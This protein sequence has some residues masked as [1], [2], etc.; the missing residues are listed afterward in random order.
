MD[1]PLATTAVEEWARILDRM[2][3]DTKWV[4]DH[5]AIDDKRLGVRAQ[6]NDL[7]QGFIGGAVDVET[8]R[9]TLDVKTRSEW[10]LFGIKG[11]SG[12]MFLNMLVKYVTDTEGLTEQLRSALACPANGDEGRSKMSTFLSYLDSL[13]ST[14]TPTK[15]QIQPARAPFLLSVCWH[16]QDVEAWPVF[17][18]SGRK[19]LAKEGLYKPTFN[20]VEDY[21]QFRNVFEKLRAVLGLGP[22]EMEHLL[23]WTVQGAAV[24]VPGP[25]VDE[26]PWTGIIAEILRDRMPPERIELRR[27][28]EAEAREMIEQ[29][30]GEFSSEMIVE[31][32]KLVSSDLVKGKERFDRF[33]P[34]LYG[35][36]VNQ[37]LKDVPA[38]NRWARAIWEADDND[39]DTV[40]NDFAKAGKVSGAGW[41]MP[42]ALLYLKNPDQYNV[43]TP[44]LQ[45]GVRKFTAFN[46][47]PTLTAD[48]YRTFNKAALEIRE[49][50]TI[51][52]Q[53]FDL[54][55]SQI[56]KQANEHPA[57][58][59]LSALRQR[60]PKW[61]GFNDPRLVEEEL[62]YK[63]AAAAQAQQLLN[64][65]E[66]RRLLDEKQFDEIISRFEKIGKG[67]HFLFLAVPKEGDLGILYQ[68]HLDRPSFCAMMFDLLHGEAYI[69]VRI[70]AY[71][72]YIKANKLPN[73][74]PFVTL[75][76]FLLDPESEIFIKQTVINPFVLAAGQEPLASPPNAESYLAVR[77]LAH[78][79][80]PALGE[81]GATDMIDVQSAIWVWNKTPVITP[82]VLAAPFSQLFQSFDEAW[83]A[84][85]L[86]HETAVSL[87]VTSAEDTRIVVSYRPDKPGI[88]LSFG[89]WLVM[90]LYAPNTFDYRV[91][92]ALQSD[93]PLV[94]D[95]IETRT[96]KTRPD[97]APVALFG[98]P[99]ETIERLDDATEALY[100]QTL[101][102]VRERFGNRKVSLHIK[103]SNQQLLDAV[104][105]EQAR[106]ALLTMG[107]A[108]PSEKRYWW[109]NFSPSIWSIQEQVP[110]ESQAYTSYNEAGNKRQ[111][112]KNFGEVREGDLIIGY[113]SAPVMKVVALCEVTA[114]LHQE[115]GQ[116]QI[117]FSKI[118]DAPVQVS[119]RELQVFNEM[120]GGK[121]LSSK[122]GSLFRLTE[123][124]FHFIAGL[125]RFPGYADP[126]GVRPPYTLDH[127][128]AGLFMSRSELEHLIDLFRARRNVILQGPPGVGKTFVAKRL[129]YA[130]MGFKAPERVGM[131]QFHQSYAYEDFIQ[132]YRPTES[133]GFALKNGVFH[134]FCRRA[135]SDPENDYV[136]IIDEINR[137]NLSKIF[138]ELM[139]L[140]EHDKRGEEWAMPLTYSDGTEEPFH[141]PENL[142]LLGMM[143][144]ADRSLAM[145]DY[146]LRR[147]FAFVDLK[148][149]FDGGQF[150]EFMKEK[151]VEASMIERIILRM[152]ELNGLIASD[153]INLGP[154]FSIGHSFFCPGAGIVADDA[155]YRRVIDTEIA[156]LVREYWFDNP[157][158]AEKHIED[159]RR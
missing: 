69:A 55:I 52:P 26:D 96:F 62:G 134:E 140:I 141:V 115:D 1:S 122:Q 11:M 2:R 49:R 88:H 76:L 95:L 110:G 155:W 119:W 132:G 89:E 85:D 14:G 128:L 139:M 24:P 63:R 17:Y 32:F 61:S 39:L 147:R 92:L 27:R 72:D 9:A 18:E 136:F 56:S 159:L 118:E 116:E 33:M 99:S 35:F 125:A 75:C 105:D 50:Y 113:E 157:D 131:I 53:A 93:D 117:C 58:L 97:E 142:Y 57:D 149:K 25:I 121:L 36:N 73:K 126:R 81:F 30:R 103:G 107:I 21:F 78:S 135:A 82:G 143:N 20:P 145:V 108:L 133:G 91:R 46:A 144:T 54:V 79:M 41:S 45:N 112:Y 129:A 19:A 74:W 94:Q 64:R 22:W 86:L 8:F 65:S 5:T 13:I 23:I 109:L 154:G 98:I 70:S 127:A 44:V 51:P 106:H 7:I 123:E 150:R 158:E 130:L 101:Q 59:L 29:K 68:E 102:Q 124:Q 66:F 138:G 3:A 137:G 28:A 38:F 42:T 148:P 120:Q 100:Q 77:E 153:K 104:F 10:D 15:R 37:M 146:A 90:G 151:N 111:I 80:L 43:W 16:M 84:F 6:L 114:S 48:G 67:K 83:L 12:A 47:L 40:L 60:Y 152:S 31:F 34:A 156:P 87:G 4:N 71:F